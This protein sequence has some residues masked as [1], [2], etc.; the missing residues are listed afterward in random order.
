MTLRARRPSAQPAVKAARRLCAGALIALTA[1]FPATAQM[2]LQTAAL[3]STEQDP[4][5]TALRQEVASRTVDI[6]AARDGY[7]PSFSLS[8][9]SSTTDSDGPGITLTVSQVLFDWG[10]I[11]SDIKAASQVR[12]QSISDL[13]M[14]VE[15]MT[16]EVAEF[17][18][19]VEIMGRKIARTRTY[20]DF[21]HRIA[22]QASDRASA[23]V[24]DNGEVARARLEIARADD[25]MSQLVSNRQ[26]AMS[27]LAYLIG[28]DPM[29]IV[30]P[31]ELKFDKHYGTAI[32]IQSAVRLS[33]DY[34]AA[35]ARAAEA[36]A[37]VEKAKAARLPTI[38][39]QAEGRVDLDGGRSQT[40]LGVS[41]GMD[42]NS[43][44][45]GRRAIQSAVLT[46]Q[47]A[48]SSMAATERDMA[49]AA[50]SSLD[51][52]QILRSSEASRAR[53]LAESQKVLDTY[54]Q[55]FSGGKRELLD[56]LTTGR[57]LYDAQIDE[58]ETYEE[59]KRTEY[60]AAHD[61]GVLGTLI[62]AASYVQ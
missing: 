33:P 1:A 48:Q 34:I 52:L 47:S 21:A 46:L 30:P 19:D 27:Q 13:K 25:Q 51:R 12:V 7:Y 11:R 58:I 38:E 55:Q 31:P 3:L 35:R 44:G 39:L 53:Q 10:K 17:F 43:R 42:L 16:L 29:A 41:A 37:G 56:L 49:N 40:A 60:R 20:V 6:E 15:D 26:I 24:S 61:L 2:T 5:I 14:A 8:G 50:K 28:Q 45:F 57:D 22:Q 59:R 36:E 32:K 9:D 62:M 23:G 4:N 54:E 18:L